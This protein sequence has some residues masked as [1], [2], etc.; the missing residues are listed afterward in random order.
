MLALTIA[1]KKAACIFHASRKLAVAQLP[2][3]TS[4]LGQAVEMPG[5]PARGAFILFEGV[6][7]CG[8]STQASK[9]VAALQQQGKDAVLW[10]FPDRKNTVSGAAINDYLQGKAEQDDR[11]IHL[12]FSVNRW[13][14]RSAL[15]K[16]LNSGTTVVVD[17][18]AYSGV[19]YSAAKGVP[20]M[21]LDWCKAPDKGLPAPDKVFYLQLDHAAAAARGGYG[22]ERYEKQAFQEKVKQMF[23]AIKDESWTTLDASQEVDA[24]SE[25][26]LSEALKV[27]DGCTGGEPIK[28]LWDHQPLESS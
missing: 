25:Q 14:K 1:Q 2:A 11:A 27:I 12:L 8:K 13:E 7:R 6:D 20:G 16:A 24:I 26:I 19:A 23:D 28:Q 10:G 3:S 9:L 4:T 22:E 5:R 15:L 21:E 18:Y 17:R